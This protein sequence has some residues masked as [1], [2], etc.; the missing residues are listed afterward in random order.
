MNTYDDDPLYREPPRNLD[1]EQALLG[2]ILVNNEAHDRVSGFLEPHHFFDPLHGA[3]YEAAAK[4]IAAG[5]QAN[6][7]TLKTYFDGAEPVGPTPVPVYLGKLAANATTIINV[8]DYGR[9]IVDLWMR[10]QLILTGED[11]VNAAYS[12][13][14]DFPP[15]EQIEEV[16]RRLYALAENRSEGHVIAEPVAVRNEFARVFEAYR[17]PEAAKVGIS[18]GLVDV[19]RK[20]GG[21]LQPSDL[22]IL[23]GRP[24]MGKTALAGTILRSIE[25][26]AVFFSLEMTAE[27]IARRMISAETGIPTDRLRSGDL[28]EAEASLLVRAEGTTMQRIE[29]RGVI[30][31]QTGGISIANLA[32]R[33]R[34]LKRQV[35]IELVIVDYLQLV[36]TG[37]SRRD[38]RVQE[39]SEISGGLKALAKEMNVPVL[40]L[41]QLSR[42]VENREDKRPHLADLRESGSIEQDADVVMF[43]FREEYYVRQQQPTNDAQRA[44]RLAKL[45]EVG[46]KGEIIVGKHRHGATGTVDVHFD[47]TTT[48]FSN[49]AH[50]GQAPSTVKGAHR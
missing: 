3:I 6:P 33:A 26:P 5:R 50:S 31:D 24:A 12:S 47:A 18:T 4:L 38:G 20:L 10:R 9:T 22:I 42:N 40:A 17:N 25:A 32:T 21:G 1:A 41:S 34:R 16:E 44:A 39:V 29:A 13:P 43:V 15:K 14:V 46:G 27:Q 7:I 36:T 28:S 23:A 35:G 48:L 37:S 49:L 30:L 45:K 11:M 2:A 8:R 19:D